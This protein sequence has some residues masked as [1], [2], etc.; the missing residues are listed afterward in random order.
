MLQSE[1]S[2]EEAILEQVK[3]Q[4]QIFLEGIAREFEHLASF[5]RESLE[6]FLHKVKSERG[7][8]QNF[9]MGRLYIYDAS[10]RILADTDRIYDEIKAMDGFQGDVI[11]DTVFHVSSKLEYGEGSPD[12]HTDVIVPARLAGENV[13][14]EVEIN[15]SKTMAKIKTIDDRYEQSILTVLLAGTLVMV[16]LLWWLI[17]QGLLK[18]IHSL[19]VV[20]ARIADGQ[21]SSRVKDRTNSEMDE[22]GRSINKMAGSIEALFRE[23]RDTFLQTIQSLAR[24]IEAKDS[25]T[26][27]HSER[28]ADLSHRLGM[29]VGLPENELELLKHGALMHDLGKIGISDAILD[30]TGSLENS[31]EE[32]M[33]SHPEVTADIMAPL[34]RFKEF[35]EIAAWHHERWDGKGYPEG[36]K[37]KE[38]PILARIVA[39]ADTWDAMTSDRRYRKAMSREE[40][41]SI[42][43]REIDEGQWDPELIDK[44]IEMMREE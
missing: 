27:G 28:V 14:F 11:R 10:G 30:K 21:F 23:Q 9:S 43:E 25:Y 20:T 8:V 7:E 13:A 44:F 33:R 31:E 35:A 5:E 18:P 3:G 1:R 39:I 41:L 40:A 22:L 37:G 19:N 6:A 29:K 12:P 17:R 16:L 34:K 38:I 42:M 2:L 36:L 4:S 32:A 15:L 24:A 26:A